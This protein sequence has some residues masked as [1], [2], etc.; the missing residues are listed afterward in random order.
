MQL[1]EDLSSLLSQREAL[2]TRYTGKHRAVQ[3]IDSEIAALRSRMQ[4]IPRYIT[5]ETSHVSNRQHD[6]MQNDLNEAR[7]ESAQQQVAR[8]RLENSI[9]ETRDQL[10]RLEA[11]AF[12][13]RSLED[14]IDANL[15][16]R[17]LYHSKLTDARLVDTMNREN[18]LSANIIESAIIAESSNDRMKTIGASFVLALI[19]ALGVVFL[20]EWRTP[21]VRN[22]DELRAVLGMPSLATISNASRG[23]PMLERPGG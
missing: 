3:R 4:Q 16:A 6:E 20:I 14:A 15:K 5:G 23:R 21:R 8:E 7:I 2:L 9:A 22:P 11:Q 13:L 17:R 10:E 18:I 1:N 19:V 12:Q